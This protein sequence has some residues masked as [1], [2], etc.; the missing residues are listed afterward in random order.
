MGSQVFTSIRPICMFMGRPSLSSARLERMGCCPSCGKKRAGA[1]RTGVEVCGGRD[2]AYVEIRSFCYF[3]SENTGM[4]PDLRRGDIMTSQ[5]PVHL[6]ARPLGNT[7][8]FTEE[9]LLIAITRSAQS[10]LGPLSLTFLVVESDLGG[11]EVR[12]LFEFGERG[13]FFG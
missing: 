13:L 8:S 6:F 7:G 1:V 12:G 3:R 11:T 2:P 9:E 4:V 10:L 5:D